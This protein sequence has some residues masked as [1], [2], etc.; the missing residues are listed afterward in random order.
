VPKDPVV[1]QS[2]DQQVPLGEIK[3]DP[4]A[5]GQFVDQ[6]ARL[7]IDVPGGAVTDDDLATG[8]G[9]LTLRVQQIAAPSGGNAGRSGHY[10]FGLYLLQIVDAQGQLAARG[11]RKP[12][13]LRLRHSS[14][15]SALDLSRVSVILNGSVPRRTNLNPDQHGPRLRQGDVRMGNMQVLSAKAETQGPPPVASTQQQAEL[16]WLPSR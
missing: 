12:V 4:R 16:G 14:R 15:E 9:G 5:A 3:L 8:G 1:P 10:S 13:D 2:F 7:Q 11:L 6:D